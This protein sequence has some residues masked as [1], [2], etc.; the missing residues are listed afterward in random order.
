MALSATDRKILAAVAGDIP[1]SL[2]PFEEMATSLG[3]PEGEL[4]SAIEQF[5]R[6]GILRRFGAAVRHRELGF[7]AN[8]MAVWRIEE[9]SA[10]DAAKIIASY[11]AVSHCYLRKSHPSWPYNLYAMIHGRTRDECERI[12]ADISR[13]IEIKEYRLLFSIREFKKSSPPYFKSREKG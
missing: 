8:A 9:E 10:E 6:E 13:R 11:R 12:A 2:T 4:L 7:A 5:R 1:D 3:I